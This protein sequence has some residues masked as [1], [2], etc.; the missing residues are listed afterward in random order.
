MVL[1][2]D[3]AY[4]GRRL[5]EYRNDFQ[6]PDHLTFPNLPEGINPHQ[7]VQQDPRTAYDRA[8]TWESVKKLGSITTMQVYLKGS[9]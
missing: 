9:E 5:N 8:F 7:F 6:L 4:L 3:C 2:V 1:T